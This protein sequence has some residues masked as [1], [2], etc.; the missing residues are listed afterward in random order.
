M[1]KK[2]KIVKKEEVKNIT[3]VSIDDKRYL[4][5]NGFCPD[6]KCN[7]ELGKGKNRTM[8]KDNTFLD[9]YK[10]SKCSTRWQF[11]HG[12]PVKIR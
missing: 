8:K 1:R 9:I 2:E 4:I 6:P 5:K 7:P 3:E 10:C 11:R 12:L